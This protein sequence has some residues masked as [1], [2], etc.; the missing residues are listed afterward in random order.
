MNEFMPKILAEYGDD[1]LDGFVVTLQLVGLSVGIGAVLACFV[2]Y[3]RMSKNRIVR[4]LAWFYTNLFR[5]TPL[6]AQ[7]FLIYYGAGQFSHFWRGI[8]LW[9][10]L[11]DPFN[12]AVLTF[13]LNTAAYQGEIFRGAIRSVPKGQ[14]EGGEAL[15]LQT[16]VIF[17]KII[18][19]QAA[20]IALRPFGNEII[21]M[22]KGSAV[23]SVVTVYDLLGET[24]LAY[25]DTFRF[26][27]Y[28]YAAALYLILVETLRRVWD[29]LE[30]RLNRHLTPRP[31]AT[32][33]PIEPSTIGAT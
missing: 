21:L 16:P 18:L 2:A 31:L 8:G 9:W 30:R 3:W 22:I 27:V 32:K 10:F 24:R 6:L 29:L 25:S 4:A 13:I 23:A 12:C 17:R 1:L 20:L 28:F 5:G 19:P 14:W 11:R 26:D 15:G 7:L 33:R